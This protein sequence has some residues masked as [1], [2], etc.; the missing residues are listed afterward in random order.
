[1][2]PDVLANAGGVTLSY[3][4]W[5]QNAL[6]FFWT[7]A[8]INARLDRTLSDDFRAIREVAEERRLPL[9]GLY[10]RAAAPRKV[11]C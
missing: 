2:L 11:A 7:E 3:F 10:P 6:S 5:V 9:R 1:V 8:D 4:E